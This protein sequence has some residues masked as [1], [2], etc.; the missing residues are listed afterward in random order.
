ME[1]YTQQES[2]IILKLY[3]ELLEPV[4]FKFSTKDLRLIFKAFRLAASAHS[5]Q[6][7]KSGEPYIYHP[8]LVATIVASRL[9]LD[10][11]SI[12]SALLHDVV[13][14]TEYTHQD[15]EDLFGHTISKI[16]AG[17]T[18]ITQISRETDVSMQA[19]NFRKMLL[20]INDDI[21]VILIKI[22]DRLHNMQT[23]ESMSEQ[24]Q[25]KIASETLY[26]YAPLAHRIGLYKIKTELEDLA[27]RYTNPDGY[28]HILSKIEESKDEQNAYIS[29]FIDFIK[30]LLDEQNI[31]CS[32]KGR[33]KS[34]YSI[35]RKMINK[36]IPYEDVYDKFAIRVIYN[37]TEQEERTTAWRIFS[38][39]T[40]KFKYNPERLRDWISNPK[41][42]GYESLHVT[43]MGPKARWVE[44]QIRSERM[45][46]IA[47]KG[48]ASHFNYKNGPQK[49]QGLESWLNRLKDLLESKDTSA[50][51]FVDDFKLNLYTKEIYVFTPKGELKSLPKGSMPLD[52]A[53]SIH[54]EVGLHTRGA[55][56]NNILVPLNYRLKSGDVVSII[57]S[58]SAS[59]SASWVDYV[60]SPRALAKIKNA[61]K[62][63]DKAIYQ[64]GKE[65]LKRKLK[66]LKIEFGDD[67]VGQLCEFFK[68]KTS[69]ELF[70][71]V[72]TGDIDNQMLR[73]FASNRSNSFFNIFR[74]KKTHYHDNKPNKNSEETVMNTIV[75]GDSNEILDYSFSK[76]CHPVPGDPIFGFSTVGDG[77][78][79][80]SKSCPNA[81][82]MNAKFAY[83]IISA[84]WSN[85]D[86]SEFQ[87][88]ISL[89]GIDRKGL[90][91]DITSEV[92][93]H[94]NIEIKNLQF[95]AEAGLFYGKL[96][97]AVSTNFA[98]NSLMASLEKV[99]GVNKVNRL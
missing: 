72:A 11:I 52:F 20:T 26:I 86:R 32:I 91:S 41:S 92:Y 50:V 25:E 76:C 12:C 94:K 59:P 97:V 87:A 89:T 73:D 62:E 31:E 30:T 56:V 54:S 67:A 90:V 95:K 8:I 63:G 9:E 28:F 48:F 51:D 53:F 58:E 93:T 29:D 37:S 42:N 38:I 60:K 46:E 44:V 17:L 21:R 36:N 1:N 96:I 2:K 7:R 14:D 33:P 22:A 64:E 66:V 85:A 15:I 80:H 77:I 16:V 88:I 23:L 39:V 65:I 10:A 68:L 71:Q 43:V 84:S 4:K 98:I 45:N 3:R 83:R 74:K 47:E 79:V 99:E 6:R 18:K 27:L 5:T 19:E 82:D 61:L 55:K 34:I 75:F 81:I 70:E 13:E 40:S 78:K 57:T 24:K 69:Q 49:D 35:Y